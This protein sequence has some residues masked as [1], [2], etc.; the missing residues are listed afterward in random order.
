[1]T[2]IK[3]DPAYDP[4]PKSGLVKQYEQF[5]RG[6]VDRFCKRYPELLHRGFVDRN[7]DPRAEP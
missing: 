4:F 7:A 2:N 6:A 5:I 3:D 1:M